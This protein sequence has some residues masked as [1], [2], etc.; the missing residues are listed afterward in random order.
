MVI[1]VQDLVS[2]DNTVDANII[3]LEK[4]GTLTVGQRQMADF[5]LL[6]K[7]SE[8]EYLEYLFLSSV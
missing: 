1:A 8:E 4:T 7:L 2:L 3:I 5:T 6:S